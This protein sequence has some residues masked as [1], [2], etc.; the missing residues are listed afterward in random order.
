MRKSLAE[1]L[2]MAVSVAKSRSPSPEPGPSNLQAARP[3][4]SL[5]NETPFKDFLLSY[6]T[7]S[8]QQRLF[9]FTFADQIH[10]DRDAP[11]IDLEDVY[12]WLGHTRRDQ[13]V[14]MLK[15]E[16]NE[17]E[18]VFTPGPLH[19]S[20]EARDQRD[21]YLIS[22]TQIKKMLLSARSQQGK[23]YRDLIITIEG[24]AYD[25]MRIEMETARRP[26][27]THK[28]ELEE[29]KIRTADLAKQVEDLRLSKVTF[30]LYAYR[31]FD[32]RYKCGFTTDIEARIKQ[33]IF[34]LA[35]SQKRKCSKKG[36]AFFFAGRVAHQDI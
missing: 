6:L 17:S 26:I 24:A 36:V 21:Q 34:F 3:K 20:V 33:H 29:Q 25:Y 13:A 23:D 31:L 9:A 27:E 8:T 19:R 35:Y 14:R 22:I 18:Y 28:S 12:I 4:W 1:R 15:T 16:F 30:W 2:K 10:R 11:V 7:D 32:N 5:G